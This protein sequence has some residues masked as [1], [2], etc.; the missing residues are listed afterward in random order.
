MGISPA[1]SEDIAKTGIITH[2]G[3]YE[4]LQTCQ[5]LIHTVFKNVYCVF[6]YLNNSPIVS[7]F[8]KE[9]RDHIRLVFQRLIKFGVTIHVE[10]CTLSVDSI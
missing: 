2:F 8:V 6:V 3:L 9:P 7:P 1:V 5:R 10:K 4:N